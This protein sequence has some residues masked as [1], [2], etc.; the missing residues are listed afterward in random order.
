MNFKAK[1]AVILKALAVWWGIFLILGCCIGFSIKVLFG[2]FFVSAKGIS[3]TLGQYIPTMAIGSLVLAVAAYLISIV[4][5]KAPIRRL[6]QKLDNVFSE[7]GVSKEYIELLCSNCKGDVKNPLY[8][9]LA[10]AY[11]CSGSFREAKSTLDRIDIISV[12]DVAQ[13]TGNFCTAAYYYA[14]A[15]L[16]Y[17]QQQ[18]PEL[19]AAAYNTGSFY[20]NELAEDSYI[21]AVKGLYLHSIGKDDEAKAALDAAKRWKLSDFAGKIYWGCALTAKARLLKALGNDDLAV[22]AA[23]QALDFKLT[24]YLEEQLKPVLKSQQA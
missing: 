13:S 15:L 2:L 14:A 20:L 7:T 5:H 1:A 17:M 3:I 18:A 19:A 21:A 11:A 22:S 10:S 6:R 4:V 16:I 23:R 12:L 9:E 8:I 24:P